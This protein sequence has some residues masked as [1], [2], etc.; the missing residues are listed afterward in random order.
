MPWAAYGQSKTADALLAVAIGRHWQ[1]DGIVANVADP[2]YVR[3]NLTKY[4]GNGELRASGMLNE[5]G[6]EVTPDHFSTPEEAAGNTVLLAASPLLEGVT[7]KYFIYN[8]EALVV[9]GGSDRT[10]GV[11]EWSIDPELADR[12]WLLAEGALYGV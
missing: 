10:S 11:A 8:Q 12:L 1:V 2:G 6:N 4:L 7:G 3:T 5:K 9:S